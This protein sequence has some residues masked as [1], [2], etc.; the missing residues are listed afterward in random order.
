VIKPPVRR[1]FF[2]EII[3]P[4]SRLSAYKIWDMQFKGS[5]IFSNLNELNEWRRWKMSV[6]NKKTG[7][8]SKRLRVRDRFTVTIRGLITN[9]KWRPPFQMR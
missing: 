7:Y 5:L 3:S 8:I 4:L 1:N 9:K 2:A 6:F